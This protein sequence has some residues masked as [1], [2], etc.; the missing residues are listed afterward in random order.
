[1]TTGIR[2]VSVPSIDLIALKIDRSVV[3]DRMDG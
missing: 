3:V 1:M 2:V